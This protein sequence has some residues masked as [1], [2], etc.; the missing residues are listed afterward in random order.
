M[1]SF[2]E[3]PRWPQLSENDIEAAV[4]A[5]RSNRLAGMPGTVVDELENAIARAQGVAHAVAVSS[6][7]AAVHLALQAAG[8]GPGDEVIVPAHTFV[9]SASPIVYLGATPVFADVTPDTHNIDVESVKSLLTERT[10]AVVAVHLNGCAADM[11]ALNALAEETGITIV[12]DMAQALGTEIG[13]K[14]V[15]GFGKLACISLFEQKVITS[16]G[17]GGVVLTNDPE[18]VD[19]LKR[20]RSHGEGPIEGKPG[21]I[22]AHE[23]GYNY[24]LTTMQAAVGVSQLATLPEQVARRREN[25]FYLNEK[26]ADVA[27]LELPFEPEG[28]VHAF[29]KYVVRAV[30]GKDRRSATEIAA[31]LRGRGVHTLLRYPYPLHHLPAFAAHRDAMCPVAERLSAE[32]FALPSHPGLDNGH[33]DHIADQVKRVLAGR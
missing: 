10:K 11:A 2:T 25:A 17:E 15:G 26:L 6:G 32:L 28:T 9:G 14:P 5:L 8:V 7:T 12:E 29:W 23:I 3:L 24:R 1:T 4:S 22:W 19:R 18:H 13:G 21:L 30:P 33:L 31:E 27:E 20:L 16:G